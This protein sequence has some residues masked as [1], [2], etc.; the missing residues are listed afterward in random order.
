MWSRMALYNIAG[1]S[2]FSSDATV[3]QYAADI[4][5]VRP[6]TIEFDGPAGS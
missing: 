4:W 1:A 3:S 2:K 6:I 5:G